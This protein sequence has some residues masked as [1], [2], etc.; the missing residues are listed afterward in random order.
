MEEGDCPP[1]S[2][3]IEREDIATTETNLATHDEDYEG[4]PNEHIQAGGEGE[5]STSSFIFAEE[6]W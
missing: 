2:T 5:Y 1:L 6:E 3:T 4:N